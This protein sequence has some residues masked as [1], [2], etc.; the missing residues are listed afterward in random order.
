MRRTGR[1]RCDGAFSSFNSDFVATAELSSPPVCT[2]MSYAGSGEAYDNYATYAQRYPRFHARS[3]QDILAY[4]S[5]VTEPM[6]PITNSN[7]TPPTVTVV[8]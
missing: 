5:T 2:V 3:T 4:L 6:T 1:R 8:T 7:F